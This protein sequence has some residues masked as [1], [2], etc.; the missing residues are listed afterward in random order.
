MIRRSG[1]AITSLLLIAHPRRPLAAMRDARGKT[2]AKANLPSKICETCLRPM[3]WR[4]AWERCW[5]TVRH[6]SDRC[7]NESRYQAKQRRAAGGAG[8][9]AP[10]L[11]PAAAAE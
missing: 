7:R 2:V 9:P 8:E 11:A 6:C 3:T 5:D 4:K 10:A 1:L